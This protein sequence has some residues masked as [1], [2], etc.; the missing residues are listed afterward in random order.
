MVSEL[1]VTPCSTTNLSERFI[2]IYR[3]YMR[4]NEYSAL[5]NTLGRI[6]GVTAITICREMLDFGGKFANKELS[7]EILIKS[8]KSKFAE[9]SG[10]YSGQ[11]PEIFANV[12]LRY[13]FE[14]IFDEISKADSCNEVFSAFLDLFNP[15]AVI[16]A[17]EAFTVE[18]TLVR[19]AKSRKMHTIGLIH[20]G[21]GHKKGFAD[22]IGDADALWCWNDID[23]YFL[24][25]FGVDKNRLHKIGCLKYESTY[26]QYLG[27]GKKNSPDAKQ[28][29]REYL[30][31][32]PGKP[33]IVFATA[34]INTG[35][36]GASASPR[37]HREAIRD[38]ISL[39]AS[40]PDL[41]FLIKPHP[42][43]DYFELYRRLLN[44]QLP[45]LGLVEGGIFTLNEVLDA[46][47][48]CVMVNYCTTAALEAM[49][50]K[51]PVIYFENAVY[52]TDDCQDTLPPD[53]IRR[54]HTVAELGDQIDS[55]LA[56]PQ[57]KA[58]ALADADNLIKTLLDVAEGPASSRLY[59]FLAH[60]F[61]A[62][63]G[64]DSRDLLNAELMRGVLRSTD[65][66][67][68]L[69]SQYGSAI[70]S[71]SNELQMYVFAYLAGLNNLGA[72]SVSKLFYAL[73]P[74]SKN[75]SALSWKQARW[76]LLPMYIAG[77]DNQPTTF[78]S[79]LSFVLSLVPYLFSPRKLMHAPSW[80][81]FAAIGAIKGI[82]GKYGVFILKFL[83][84]IYRLVERRSKPHERSLSKTSL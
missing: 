10:N 76:F 56:D 39:V 71:S 47:D 70:K 17:H 6:P 11:H 16:F 51:V 62:R 77:N 4:Q 24:R 66:Q 14:G 75:D 64:V 73:R 12:N 25:L 7:A 65:V 1:T 18:R 36:V 32:S 38:I 30:G 50:Q 55:L 59:D 37:K 84:K 81:K 3:Q 79:G 41:Q 68:S 5:K 42:G 21:L 52:P 26:D 72:G 61:E 29:A 33:L 8:L 69:Y 63:S 46:A 13:Q 43:Y 2:V 9:L 28:K 49:L 34:Q 74:D 19:S 22:I 48:I 31:I 45:N 78:R 40:R 67:Q 82:S 57:E 15:S 23:I 58:H 60:A 27:D 80:Y 44:N 20:G 54:V 53:S 35:L 83:V